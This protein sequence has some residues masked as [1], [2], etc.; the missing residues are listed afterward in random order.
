[1]AQLAVYAVVVAR[2]PTARRMFAAG[3]LLAAAVAVKATTLP[4]MII[5]S[6]IVLLQPIEDT[7]LKR[8]GRNLLMLWA[9][10][11]SPLL[12]VLPFLA[13]CCRDQLSAGA[14]EINLLPHFLKPPVVYSAAIS[15]FVGPF[16]RTFNIWAAGIFFSLVACP[17]RPRDAVNPVLL[18]HFV[19]S[20][21]WCGLYAPAML[22]LDY[23][24]DR[25]KAHILIPLAINIVTG[26]TLAEVASQNAAGPAAAGLSRSRRSVILALVAL[27]NAVL[28]AP[29]LAG[30]AAHIGID[31][32]RLR[33]QFACVLIAAI[34]TG[35]AVRRS[36]PGSRPPR[37]F[38]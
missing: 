4:A 28:W 3:L 20:A 13:T 24:P 17:L 33:V 15:S 34:L 31:T 1:V 19:S 25:Y 18:Q 10:F 32:T 36:T 35:W 16:A 23:F 38:F 27:P 26:V 5:F 6:A 29:S 22:S 37:I 7:P 8:R 12:V 9:G 11:L 2:R 30:A 21:I 14:L